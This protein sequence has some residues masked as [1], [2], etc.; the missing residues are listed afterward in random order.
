MVDSTPGSCQIL[1][2]ANGGH[3]SGCRAN[4]PGTTHKVAQEFE[5]LLIGQLL[6]AAK[7][8]ALGDSSAPGS[9]TMMDYAQESL[10]RLLSQQGG[11]GLAP[12]IEAG[13]KQSDSQSSKAQGASPAGTPSNVE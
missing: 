13:L 2:D 9:D 12:M 7:F 3:S 11:L 8:N 1:L 6:K 4:D 10:A 5:A